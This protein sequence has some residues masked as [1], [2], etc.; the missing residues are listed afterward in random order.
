[1]NVRSVII[2]TTGHR[3]AAKQA[4]ELRYFDEDNASRNHSLRPLN[5]K[6]IQNL[7]GKNRYYYFVLSR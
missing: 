6:I 3:I 1:M 4:A 2:K 7:T 5:S